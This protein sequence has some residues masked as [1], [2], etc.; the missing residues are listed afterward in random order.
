LQLRL[1][2]APRWQAKESATVS[3]NINRSEQ[4]KFLQHF[5][6]YNYHGIL[7]VGVLG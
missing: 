1:A 5:W 2:R 6:I 4:L 3:L 7:M